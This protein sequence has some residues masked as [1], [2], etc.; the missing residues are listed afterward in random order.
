[1]GRVHG[2]DCITIGLTHWSKVR[3]TQATISG[4]Q[5]GSGGPPNGNDNVDPTMPPHKKKNDGKPEDG[6]AAAVTT[7]KTEVKPPAATAPPPAAAGGQT[8]PTPQ[9]C[10]KC[11]ETDH[12]AK[13]YKVQGPLK[14]EVHSEST[15][16]MT[17]A[18]N[19]LRQDSNLIVHPWLLKQ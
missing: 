3:E 9:Y 17:K 15:S 11:G 1:M 14:Y 8:P 13:G 4:K 6:V 7:G 18:C 5:P 2:R 19:K 16:H 12:T 10:F